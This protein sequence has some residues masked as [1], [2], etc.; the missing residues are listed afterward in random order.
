M[1]SRQTYPC[2]FISDNKISTRSSV[3]KIFLIWKHLLEYNMIGIWTNSSALSTPA[4]PLAI[5]NCYNG[6]QSTWSFCSISWF[7][8]ATKHFLAIFW[9]ARTTVTSSSVGNIIFWGKVD[10]IAPHSM[11]PRLPQDRRVGWES[12]D[13]DKINFN[14]F[15]FG[16]YWQLYLPLGC[17]NSPIKT[18]EWGIIFT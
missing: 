7:I 4:N 6:S 18:Y 3:D 2:F 16:Y 11:D 14:L 10:G 13:H 8:A 9:L 15:P 5:S 12:I 1:N 17:H